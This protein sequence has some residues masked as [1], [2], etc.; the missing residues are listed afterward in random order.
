MSADEETETPQVELEPAIS[1]IST[2]LAGKK[3]TKK[4]LKITKKASKEKAVKRGVKEVVK[5]LRKG[6]KGLCIIAGDIS[7]IDVISHVPVL[8]EDNNVPYIYVP[9]K[10]ALGAASQ[11]KRPTSCVIVAPK[12]GSS[13]VESF[14]A[15]LADV[16][17]L[18][19]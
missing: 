2:P 16:K 18:Q 1:K 17:A 3:L 12:A 19:A 4:L 9:A 5:A 14:D 13:L 7:P 15:A 11:T 8:C 6:E 10:E